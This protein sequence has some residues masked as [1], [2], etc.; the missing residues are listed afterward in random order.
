MVMDTLAEPRE[1]MVLVKGIYNDTTDVTVTANVPSMLPPLPPKDGDTRYTRLDLARWIVSPENPLTARVIVNRYWQIFFGRGIVSTPSD[2]GLQG[3]PADAPRTVRLVGGGVHRVR[4][5]RQA[6]AS[7]DRHQSK[8][9]ANLPASHEELL[10][11]DPQ[12]ELL[13]RAPR[14][15]M[16][17]WMIR[18][19]SLAASGMLNRKSGRGAGQ[20]LSTGRDLGRSHIWKDQVSNGQRRKALPPFALFVLAKDR[21]ADHVL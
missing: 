4:V 6:T 20:I 3:S 2:F 7:L 1:T 15:R 8:P 5:E 12:N 14:H 17:S 16:P 11:R 9:I 19:A 13:A 10:E 21:R 18:D